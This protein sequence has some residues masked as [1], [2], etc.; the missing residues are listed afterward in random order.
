MT[1]AKQRFENYLQSRFGDTGKLLKRFE[2]Y[3]QLLVTANRNVNL[4]SRNLPQDRYWIQHFLDSLLALECLD[5]SDKIVL[6]FGTGGG[7]PGI[8][9]KLVLP[10]LSLTLL[11]SVQKKTRILHEMAVE[12]GLSDL[13]VETARLEDYAF[14]ARRPSFDYVLCRAVALEERYIPPLRRLLKPSGM[15]VFYK[16]QKLEDLDRLRYE[17]LWE[18]TDPELGLRR[19]VGVKQKDLM[20]R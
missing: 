1:E 2:H 7:L 20:M 19:L 11:D 10:G 18:K 13:V 16:A 9:L 17:I 14:V 12:L 15:A 6:D 8:P 5:L 4:V 3:H